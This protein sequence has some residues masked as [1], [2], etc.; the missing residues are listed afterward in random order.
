ME[1]A[2]QILEDWQGDHARSEEIALERGVVLEEWRAGQDAGSRIR[3]KR[4]GVIRRSRY[5]ERL[6][7]G[8]RASERSI[9]RD[10]SASIRSG[11]APT[12]GCRGHG[13]STSRAS[14]G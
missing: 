1:T 2:M 8:T 14:N 10:C 9:A 4:A 13:V 7:I 3:D 12:H 11:I 6:P 5:T